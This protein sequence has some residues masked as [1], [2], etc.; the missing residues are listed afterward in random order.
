MSA[1]R[2][3]KVLGFTVKVVYTSDLPDGNA[4]HCKPVFAEIRIDESL[5]P[6]QQ[7]AVLFHE[8]MHFIW[9]KCRDADDQLNEEEVC[10][11]VENLAMLEEEI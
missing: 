8:A 9:S 1:F 7:R 2:L 11:L 4:G 10:T 5:P 3:V 6:Q